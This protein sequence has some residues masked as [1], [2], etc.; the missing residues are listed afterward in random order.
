M[1]QPVVLPPT[2]RA[3]A[4]KAL[5]DAIDVAYKKERAMADAALLDLHDAHQVT[6]LEITL[7]GETAAIASL[8]VRVSAASIVVADEEGLLAWVRSRYPTEIVDVNCPHCEGVLS[9]EVRTA[10]RTVLLKR[11]KV[12]R[13]VNLDH[14]PALLEE[15]I[16]DHDGEVI[17]WARVVPAGPSST[18]L[19]FKGGGR[20]AI[21]AAYRGGSLSLGQ[22]LALTTAAEDPA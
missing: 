16:Y 8:S 18:T 9:S 19:T 10:F 17:K 12:D 22:M 20:D 2:V 4:L 13:R 3:A 6:A 21:A 11:L 7:P 14:Q 15:V 1:S 5:L